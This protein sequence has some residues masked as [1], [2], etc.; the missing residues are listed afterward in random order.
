LGLRWGITIPE[1]EVLEKIQHHLIGFLP[2]NQ[3]INAKQ[4]VDL[5]TDSVEMVLKK[6]KIPVLSVGTGFYLKAFL[7][8]IQEL[9]YSNINDRKKIE[10]MLPIERLELLRTID[11]KALTKI[12]PND[13]YRIVRALE[14]GLK[15]VKWSD[16]DHVSN[17]GFMNRKDL[18]WSGFFIEW[19]RENLYK[20]IDQRAKIIIDKGLVDETKE[21]VSNW[22][23]EAPALNSLGYNFALEFIDRKISFDTLIEKFSQCHRNYAKK[24]ITW[25]KKEKNLVHLHWKKILSVFKKLEI[26]G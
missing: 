4:F 14:L 21:L 24:Q 22:G 13:T 12:H 23:L 15:G 18:E 20:R 26:Y 3:S 1:P 11:P 16:F 5:A 10:E 2:P 17:F 8:G 25:F 6:N 7:T 9:P 19:D